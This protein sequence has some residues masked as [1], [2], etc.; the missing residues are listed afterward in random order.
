M[1]NP[2][3]DSILQ[4]VR[5]QDTLVA[6]GVLDRSEGIARNISCPFHSLGRERSPSGR[7]YGE[8]E[9]APAGLFYCF[10]CGRAWNPINFVMDYKHLEFWES[11]RWLEKTFSVTPVYSST[12]EPA[13]LISTER[14]ISSISPTEKLDVVDLILRKHR[15]SFPMEKF[16]MYSDI[17][18]LLRCQVEKED[19]QAMLRVDKFLE[20]LKVFAGYS[21]AGITT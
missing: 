3:V 9:E 16:R 17:S 8:S 20:K 10:T 2:R 18:D 21:T 14:V 12:P 1:E 19:H 15:S 7:C 13:E 5:I 6:L 11:V 4:K